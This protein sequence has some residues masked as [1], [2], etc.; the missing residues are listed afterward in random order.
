MAS[1]IKPVG[2][3]GFILR[4]VMATML[5]IELEQLLPFKTLMNPSVHPF[6]L[7]FVLSIVCYLLIV[8]LMLSAFIGRLLDAELSLSFT[9]P[10]SL[11]WA[12]STMSIMFG[13][14]HWQIGLADL[15]LI[16]LAGALFPG[17]LKPSM[18]AIKEETQEP[19]IEMPKEEIAEPVPV[20]DTKTLG[21]N[22]PKVKA[23][24]R[25]VRGT[26]VR[27]EIEIDRSVF[28]TALIVIG[29][30]WLLL[31]FIDD[32]SGQGMGTWIAWVGYLVLGFFWF[33][34]V[35]G[36]FNDAGI[37]GG[38]LFLF[39]ML[40]SGVSLIPLANHWIDGYGAFA[41]FV[42][43]QIPIVFLRSNPIREESLLDSSSS[44]EEDKCLRDPWEGIRAT[45]ANEPE[46]TYQRPKRGFLKDH[47][48][49]VAN[50]SP[51]KR[52]Y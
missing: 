23:E 39:L 20:L 52:Q 17:K 14:H 36:R 49:G 1:S 46:V 9:I 42:L 38:K 24:R 30:L 8:A 29:C 19:A 22:P 21:K 5:S 32:A 3:I 10:L 28:L 27:K 12:L 47:G 31:I 50:W 4:I 13:I 51:R 37:P 11:L 15:V 45:H 2:R 43:V 26:E 35:V 40:V 44:D 18:I 25:S 6:R 7:E 34:F 48:L 33:G 41:I 16:L